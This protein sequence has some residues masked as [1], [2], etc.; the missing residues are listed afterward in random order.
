MQEDE[1]D[2]KFLLKNLAK[3]IQS[4]E[5]ALNIDDA[6]SITRTFDTEY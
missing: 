6:D 2:N 1:E 4:L 3:R 5:K